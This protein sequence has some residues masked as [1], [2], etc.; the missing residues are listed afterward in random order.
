MS[1][2]YRQHSIEKSWC[3][4]KDCTGK[5]PVEIAESSEFCPFCK[6]RGSRGYTKELENQMRAAK[7]EVKGSLERLQDKK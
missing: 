1:K 2:W 6:N 7:V 3:I 4:C 5:V